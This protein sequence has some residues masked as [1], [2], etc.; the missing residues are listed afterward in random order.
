MSQ[1]RCS[2]EK[3][4]FSSLAYLKIPPIGRIII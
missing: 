4:I 2:T 3:A 1:Q